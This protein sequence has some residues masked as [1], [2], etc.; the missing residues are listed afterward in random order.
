MVYVRVFCLCFPLGKHG[1]IVSSLTLRSL[2]HFEF[3]F[4]YGTREYIQI[5]TLLF[6]FCLFVCSVFGCAAQGLW[7]LSSP[8]RDQ[9]WTTPVKA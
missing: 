5:Y 9:T 3:I 4:I 8:T 6:S 2:I 1:F 7:D